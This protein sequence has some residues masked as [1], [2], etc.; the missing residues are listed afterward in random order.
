VTRVNK[1]WVAVVVAALLVGTLAGVVWARPD[2]SPRAAERTRKVTLG[3]GNFFPITNG[4][5]GV[6]SNVGDVLVCSSGYCQLSAPVVFP[7]LPSVIVERVK[8]HVFDN[9][10]SEQALITL[11]RKIPSSGNDKIL[12]G[13]GSPTGTSGGLQTYTSGAI[14][15]VVW[16]SQNAWIW[17]GIGG[18]NIIV[19]GV[20]VEYH[21]NV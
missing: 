14:N 21:R 18:P 19:H 6:Y 4:T 13:T 12:G 2:G 16:P 20:T 17:L 3:P 9:N 11:H 1:S 7:C 15:K 8:L 5:T 10:G